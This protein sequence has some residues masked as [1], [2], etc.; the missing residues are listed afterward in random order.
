[1][2]QMLDVKVCHILLTNKLIP[3]FDNKQNDLILCGTSNEKLSDDITKKD[4]GLKLENNQ[5]VKEVFE[6]K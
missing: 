6:K 2:T 1:M 4:L 5:I 3:N